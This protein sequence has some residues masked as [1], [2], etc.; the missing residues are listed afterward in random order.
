MLCG[1]LLMAFA[2]CQ[3]FS[4]PPEQ[5][6]QERAGQYKDTPTGDAVGILGEW[7]YYGLCLAR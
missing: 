5:W 7:L 6:S 4:M 1:M 2:G 3:T